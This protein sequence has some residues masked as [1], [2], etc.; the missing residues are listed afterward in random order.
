MGNAPAVT[1][2]I[3]NWNGLAD[4]RECLHSLQ[5]AP[6]SAMRVIVVDNGSKGD[7]ATTLEREFSS[8][9]DVL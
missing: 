7:E 5:A 6:Y 4:T 9:I 2:I 3:L 8:F 1:I